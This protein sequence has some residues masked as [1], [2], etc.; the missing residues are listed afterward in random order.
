MITGRTL[1]YGILADPIAQVRTPA[2]M[3]RLFAEQGIDAVVVPFHL[4]ATD[5]G[6]AWPAFSRLRSLGGLI[7]TVPHKAAVTAL[8]D[9]VGTAARLVGAANAVRREADGRL[10]CEMFDGRGFVG[11]LAAQGIGPAGKRVLLLGAGGAAAAIAFALAE[12]GCARVTIANRTAAKAE[13]LAARVRHAFPDCDAGV[14]PAEPDGHELVVNGTSLG[15]RPEDPLPLDAELLRPGMTVAE[16]VMVPERTAL[17]D[18]AER[19]GCRVHLGHHMLDA[20]V[21]LLAD[22]LVPASTADPA[23]AARTR[24][25]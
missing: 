21:R 13:D 11:G 1:V 17:L 19:R 5:L 8:C 3:N 6:A 24:Q 10:R 16:V 7:V 14:G 4:A 12:A 22:F 2:V 25:P 9:E 18:A 20:Q 23:G 15:L